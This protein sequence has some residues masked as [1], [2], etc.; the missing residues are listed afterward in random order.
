[1]EY[2]E[3]SLLIGKRYPTL[4]WVLS[5]I[6]PILSWVLQG[7]LASPSYQ[8]YLHSTQGSCHQVVYTQANDRM[9]ASNESRQLQG[10]SQAA[11]EKHV[12]IDCVSAEIRTS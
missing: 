11:H 10:V 12:R 5:R 6:K 2:T 1:M 3:I 9:M 7:F 4:C 8:Q